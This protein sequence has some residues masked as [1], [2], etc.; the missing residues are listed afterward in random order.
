ML[1]IEHEIMK[2]CIRNVEAS[3]PAT[4]PGNAAA[5]VHAALQGRRPQR[6]CRACGAAAAGLRGHD[7]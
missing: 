7:E 6:H 1:K 4:Q 2:H 5:E 3:S